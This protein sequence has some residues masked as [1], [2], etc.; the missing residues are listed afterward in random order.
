MTTDSGAGIELR[1][2]D[3]AESLL[4]EVGDCLRESE[5]EN[6]LVL[7]IC[8]AIVR[9]SYAERPSPVLLSIHEQGKAAGVAMMTPPHN[10]LL[11]RLPSEAIDPLIELLITEEIPIPGVSAPTPLAAEFAKRWTQR[12]GQSRKLEVSLRNYT[13]ESVQVGKDSRGALRG[14]GQRDKSLLL[15]WVNQFCTELDTHPPQR[16]I[17]EYIDEAIDRQEYFFWGREQPVTMAAASRDTGRG[18]AINYVYT[19]AEFRRN[20]Y[21][22]ACVADLTRRLLE[23][24][25]GFCC[26]FAD[27]A[28]PTSNSIYQKIGYQP[29]SDMQMWHFE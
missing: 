3:S 13:C 17:E 19:P 27:L 9:G 11:T 29:M 18:I 28:N 22:T 26:L 16:S 1:R 23:S 8:D 21:A 15:E 4:R 5:A 10:L 7:G 12:T 25:K 24:G 2:W 20:G 14:A 6:N